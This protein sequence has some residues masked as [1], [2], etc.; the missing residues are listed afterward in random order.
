[1]PYLNKDEYGDKVYVNMGEDVSTATALTFVL[2]PKIGDSLEKSISDGVA[3]G[4]SNIDVGDESYLANQ[5]L[6]Y[7]NRS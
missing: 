5:Y 2:Q 1:M 7:F 3:V 6:E 4:A